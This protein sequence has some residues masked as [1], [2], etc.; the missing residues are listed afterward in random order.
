[1]RTWSSGRHCRCSGLAVTDVN[2]KNLSH[3]KMFKFRI[4]HEVGCYEILSHSRIL[5][6]I[7]IY[8][9]EAQKK[10]VRMSERTR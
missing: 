7:L 10:V 9:L 6:I 8:L 1:M 2:R 3:R 5:S 4:R